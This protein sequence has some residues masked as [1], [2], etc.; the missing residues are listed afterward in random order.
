M[1]PKFQEE[2]TA[3]KLRTTVLTSLK[4]AEEEEIKRIAFPA[5]GAG[6]YGIAPDLCGQVMVEQIATHLEGETGISEVVICVLDTNQYNA[7]QARLAALGLAEKN[8]T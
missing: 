5:M 6:Y 2:D 8:P 1:G 3:D 4:R 7:F